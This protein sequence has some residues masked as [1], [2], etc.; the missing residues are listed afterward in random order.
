VRILTEPKNAL[1]KQY[2]A[3]LATEGVTIEWTPDA[4]ARARPHRRRRQHAH[5]NIGARRLH[6]ELL[7]D[8]DEIG[9]AKGWRPCWEA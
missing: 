7:R 8:V 9:V 2:T 4:D 6:T 1:T 5:Q 3:L